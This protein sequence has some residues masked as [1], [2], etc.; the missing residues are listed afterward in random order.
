MIVKRLVLII[1]IF[2]TSSL[3][4]NEDFY[5]DLLEEHMAHGQLNQ[6]DVKEQKFNL[7]KD[8]EWQGDFQNQVRGVASSLKLTKETIKLKNP[9][10]EISVK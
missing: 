2:F 5:S 1:S 7:T 3:L 6:N 9:A 4:A 8:K 10:I